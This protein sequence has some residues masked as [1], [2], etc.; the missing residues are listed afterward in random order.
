M[1]SHKLSQIYNK[2]LIQFF[3]YLYNVFQYKSCIAYLSVQSY[4][5]IPYGNTLLQV[6]LE[7]A[8]MACYTLGPGW[9]TI[10]M[11]GSHNNFHGDTIKLVLPLL[12]IVD[13]C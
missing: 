8:M 7:A 12:V 10:P 11:I 5:Y 2:I 13:L 1:V 9:G 6:W 4:P 3:R